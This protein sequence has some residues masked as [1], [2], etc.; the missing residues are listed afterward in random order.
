[1]DAVLVDDRL[2]HF[3]DLRIGGQAEI[4]LRSEVEAREILTPLSSLA[5]QTASGACSVALEYG[6]KPWRRRV[7]CQS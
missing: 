6:H 5:E 1:M 2:R 3:L 7:C 4:I